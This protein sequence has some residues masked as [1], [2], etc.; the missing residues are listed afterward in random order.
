MPWQEDRGISGS[1]RTRS[2]ARDGAGATLA[3]I[4][5]VTITREGRYSLP[6]DRLG[7]P[8]N[9]TEALA[10]PSRQPASLHGLRVSSPLEADSDRLL[11]LPLPQISLLG[12]FW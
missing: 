12:F 3:S 9:A 2:A 4:A 5:G 8:R 6:K 7:T 1:R 11:A 10:T